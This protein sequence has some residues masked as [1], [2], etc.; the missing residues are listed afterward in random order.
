[1]KKFSK[2]QRLKNIAIERLKRNRFRRL[3]KKKVL[4][5]LRFIRELKQG[6]KSN[7]PIFNKRKDTL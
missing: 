7:D 5:P 3:I 2:K 1:M 4:L 6:L